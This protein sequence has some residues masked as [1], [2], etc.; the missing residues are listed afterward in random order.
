MEDDSRIRSILS[1]RKEEERKRQES[2]MRKV[3]E[4]QEKVLPMVKPNR[5]EEEGVWIGWQSR[6][7]QKLLRLEGQV[8][9]M[10]REMELEL[11]KR[12][13]EL[14]NKWEARLREL[15]QEGQ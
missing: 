14:E 11:E 3:R 8:D 10:R 6:I 15:A 1:S 4:L 2:A 7:E 9:N 5:E 13:V 12:V